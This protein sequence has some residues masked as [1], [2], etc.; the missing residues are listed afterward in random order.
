ML[1]DMYMSCPV[2]TAQ[3]YWAGQ[4]YWLHTGPC[5]GKLAIDEYAYIHCKKCR[6]KAKV[7]EMK[8]RCNNDRHS[9][10]VPTTN[11]FAAAITNA[12]Q[13]TDA[14]GIAWLQSMLKYLG[15]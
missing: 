12:G 11:G 10:G 4:E 5:K 1:I 14:A 6:K 13:M 7:T 15:S 9:F 3:G 2:C 8:F